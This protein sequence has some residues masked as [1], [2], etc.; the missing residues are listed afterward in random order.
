MDPREINTNANATLRR[1]ARS[2]RIWFFA[3]TFLSACFATTLLLGIL[4]ANGFSLAEL[5]ALPLCFVLFTWISGAFWTSIAGFL[6]R[7]VGRD[8]A[9]LDSQAVQGRALKSRTAVVMCI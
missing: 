8:P 9:L 1:E 2:R 7:L 5:V 4:D 3:L 6:V